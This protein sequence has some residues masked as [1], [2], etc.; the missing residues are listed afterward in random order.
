MAIPLILFKWKTETTPL[1]IVADFCSLCGDLRS[2]VLYE[3]TQLVK[4]YA[5]WKIPI[6]QHSTQTH[7]KKCTDCGAASATYGTKYKAVCDEKL[8]LEEVIHHTF[9]DIREKYSEQLEFQRRLRAGELSRHERID[10][11]RDQFSAIEPFVRK[12]IGL[13]ALL[14]TVNM[15]CLIAALLAFIAGLTAASLS[16]LADRLGIAVGFSAFILFG[17]ASVPAAIF[18]HRRKVREFINNDIVPALIR[19]LKPLSP[20]LEELIA[21]QA[22]LRERGYAVVEIMDPNLLMQRMKHA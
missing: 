22:E 7:V 11:L 9:P 13:L 2:F 18:V 6:D 17:I 3:E 15:G 10:V 14:R 12:E 4:F 8:T 21:V 19:M 16:R 5:L 1:G 20:T